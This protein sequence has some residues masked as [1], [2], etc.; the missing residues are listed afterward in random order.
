MRFLIEETEIANAGLN[1]ENTVMAN[2][3]SIGKIVIFSILPFC[4]VYS[5]QFRPLCDILLS[6]LF[7]SVLRYQLP[8][9]FVPRLTTIAAGM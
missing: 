8:N 6:F 1:K 3:W 9:I 7:F 5:S 2:A 4:L